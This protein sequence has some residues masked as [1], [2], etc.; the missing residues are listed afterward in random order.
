MTA[1]AFLA[2]GVGAALGAWL[3]WMLSTWFNP[4]APTLPLGTLAASAPNNRYGFNIGIDNFYGHDCWWQRQWVYDHWDNVR[5]YL[6]TR[7]C[8]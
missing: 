1:S 7:T 8:N 6:R 4:V 5:Y 3:R 2:V